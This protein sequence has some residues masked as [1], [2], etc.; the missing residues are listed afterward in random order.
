M[1]E[2]KTGKPLWARLLKGGLLAILVTFKTLWLTVWT[3]YQIALGA[4]LV[5]L[6]WSVWWVA[7]Y[8]SVMDIRRLRHENP[9]STAFIEVE[10]DRL[11]DSLRIA[12][13]V[14]RPDTLVK[15]SWIPLDSIPKT[16]R[17]AVLVAEDA[18]FFEHQG[19]DLEQI[20]YAM[21][22]NHQAGK[23]AR[24]ASTITQQVA[25]NLYLSK[26]KE[27]SRKARE[28]VITLL[29]ENQLPKERI[30]EIYLNIA[31]FDEGV[32]GIREAARR[33]FRKEPADLTQ[34]EAINLVCLLPSPVKWNFK[35]PGGA[36]A[37]HK[38]LVLRN[39]ALFKGM[40]LKMDTTGTGWELVT[41]SDLAEQLSEERWKGL[42]SRPYAEPQPGGDT[43]ATDSGGPAAGPWPGQTRGPGGEWNPPV[44]DGGS[45]GF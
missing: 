6:V 21:V 30:L 7:E 18:K 10:R 25:K 37:Q 27:L 39:Y 32:F 2:K 4:V 5:G 20:E 3:L 17:E 14:P 24:G 41:Y 26:D 35:R 38:R 1:A 33:H 23:K 42:R 36:F 12:G 8:F 13:I 44:P 43:A 11:S 45:G 40:K 19:F 29:L 15:W 34:D 22:A 31:Q 28:A 16:I 9:K